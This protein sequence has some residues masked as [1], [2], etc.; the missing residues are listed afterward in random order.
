MVLTPI[1]S[2]SPG[3]LLEIKIVGPYP[4]PGSQKLQ[5]GMQQSVFFQGL[6]I[7]LRSNQSLRT[8]AVKE[9]IVP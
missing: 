8:A 7:I 3:V 5:A 1:V 9:L 6:W 2:A 4:I